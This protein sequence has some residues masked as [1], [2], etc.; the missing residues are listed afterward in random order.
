MTVG[1]STTVIWGN[2]CGYFHGNVTGKAFN[3]IW[4][5]ATPCC[6]EIDCKMNDLECLFHVK[7]C[8]WPARLSRAYLCVSQAFLYL[9]GKPTLC[10]YAIKKLSQSLVLY[11]TVSSGS[12]PARSFQCRDCDSNHWEQT[13]RCRLP[14]VDVPL[15][16]YDS[17]PKLLQSPRSFSLYCLHEFY[18][19]LMMS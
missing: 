19:A 12:L 7:I 5:Y 17:E 16:T 13:G 9:Y 3:I 8:F 14:H 18:T 15:S 10:W 2:L 1:L 11:C 6:P 4:W